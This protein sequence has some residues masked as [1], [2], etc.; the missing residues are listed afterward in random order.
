M[1]VGYRRGYASNNTEDPESA[2]Y[3]QKTIADQQQREKELK[4]LLELSTLA[5]SSDG[6]NSLLEAKTQALNNIHSQKV[7]SLMKSIHQLQEQ[8]SAMQSQD[9]EHRRSALIQSLRKKQR[10]Q[11]LLIDVLK[12]SLATKA[13]EFQDSIPLVNEFILKKTLGGPKRFRPKTREELELEFLELDKKYK[14]A[15]QNAKL[16]KQGQAA[17]KADEVPAQDDPETVESD[18]VDQVIASGAEFKQFR[19]YQ[20]ITALREEVDRLRITIASKDVNLNA[21]LQQIELLQQ[22]VAQ[23]LTIQDKFERTK[24]KYTASKEALEKLEEDAIRL[25]QEKEKESEARTQAEVELAM[26]RET[27][28]NDA[29]SCDKDKL[30]LLERIKL[31]HEHEA[32]LQAQM[33]DQQ[34]KWCLDRTTLNAQLRALEKQ[35]QTTKEEAATATATY[36][37]LLRDKESMSRKIMSLTDELAA[38]TAA[39]VVLQQDGF[40]YMISGRRNNTVKEVKWQQAIDERD[41]KLKAL[42]KQVVASK[43]LARQ[44]KKEKEQLLQQ[45]DRLR[46]LLAEAAPATEASKLL[47]QLKQSSDQRLTP[48]EACQQLDNSAETAA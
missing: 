39:K 38:A 11:D 42:D 15:L 44:S 5:D 47:S 26:V 12:E 45:I 33:E 7:R 23:L 37:A 25:V 30:D 21:Q 2:R 28:A 19:E 3:A 24:A 27:H 17:K 29:A 31:M 6:T 32:A 1:F 43:L 9:K 46:T 4:K 8:V 36:E 13:P 18:V 20:E 34:K 22:Q 16:A 14:R 35:L 40:P 41:L 48:A 10:E